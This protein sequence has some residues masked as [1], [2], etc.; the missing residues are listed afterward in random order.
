LTSFHITVIAFAVLTVI[1]ATLELVARRRQHWPAIAD[2]FSALATTSTGR[3]LVVLSWW[4]L[5]WHFFVR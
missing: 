4:W 2:V 1:A 5:G 3:F